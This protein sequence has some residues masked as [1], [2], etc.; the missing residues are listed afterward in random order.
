ML[1]DAP[2]PRGRGVA[3][4][5][6]VQLS[7]LYVVIG[8]TTGASCY[9]SVIGARLLFA[10]D[11]LTAGNEIYDANNYNRGSRGFSCE[12]LSRPSGRAGAVLQRTL[13]G[14]QD[15]VANER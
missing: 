9:M 8:S 11:F 12:E 6:S 5:L 7:T 14:H 1:G 4:A 3:G 13:R 10:G 15:R 2:P